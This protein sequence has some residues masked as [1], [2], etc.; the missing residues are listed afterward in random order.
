MSVSQTAETVMNVSKWA[1]FVDHVK[2]NRIEYLLLMG[3]LHIAG[4]TQIA[5]SNVSGVC[6]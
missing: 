4:I 5:Y 6:L 2:N 3:I 1:T